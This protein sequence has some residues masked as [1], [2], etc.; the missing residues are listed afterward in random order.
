[1]IDLLVPSF[2]REPAPKPWPDRD[3]AGMPGR[4]MGQDAIRSMR[5]DTLKR[6][7]YEEVERLTAWRQIDEMHLWARE[8][9]PG[10]PSKHGIYLLSASMGGGK[11]LWAIAAAMVAWAHRAVPVFSSESMGALFG[12]RLN[13][14]QVYNFPDVVP[15]GSI[16]LLDEIAALADSH[17]GQAVR[18]RVLHASTT[19]FRKGGNLAL[20]ATA[21]ESMLAWQ[22]KTSM[23]AVIEPRIE[24]PKKRVLSG[25]DWMGRPQY[26]SYRLREHELKY[27]KFCYLQAQALK[28][29]WEGRRVFED[30]RASQLAETAPQRRG[31]R[32]AW[33][34]EDMRSAE[35][36]VYDLAA[37][38]YDTFQR[39]PISDQ[40]GLSAQ[41]MRDASDTLRSGGT[42]DTEEPL[43]EFFRWTQQTNVLSRYGKTGSI[44]FKDLHEA[45]NMQDERVFRRMSGAAFTRAVRQLLPDHATSTRAVRL[46]ELRRLYGQR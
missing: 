46:E 5:P 41:R 35:P 24:M 31:K 12:Y 4:M 45:A 17:S 22:L 36:F 6:D 8:H 18:G 27:P 33:K 37:R 11:S 43:I 38:L 3:W 16:V 30:Y 15:S 20:T 29:P 7:Q 13:L 40:H 28:T 39:V 44:P 23:E 42:L 25:H 32:G 34:L 14:E 1:M 19:T 2:E 26:G 21:A 9:N 10:I